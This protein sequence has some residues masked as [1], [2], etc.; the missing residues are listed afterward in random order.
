MSGERTTK[1]TCSHPLPKHVAAQP[2]KKR[3]LKNTRRKNC[4]ELRRCRQRNFR[5][6]AEAAA[7]DWRRTG[8]DQ[9][10]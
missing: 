3:K 7:R 8:A 6:K 2:A 10:P 1:S 9:P 5:A 4:G